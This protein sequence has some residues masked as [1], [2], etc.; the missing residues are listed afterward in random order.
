MKSNLWF[1][2]DCDKGAVGPEWKRLNEQGDV[3]WRR[4]ESPPKCLGCGLRMT[5]LI[6]N[7]MMVDP[8]PSNVAVL[9][10]TEV[11]YFTSSAQTVIS[12]IET[13]E[14]EV[15]VAE[16]RVNE[17]LEIPTPLEHEQD[18]RSIRE[19]LADLEDEQSVC[20]RIHHNECS[21]DSAPPAEYCSFCGWSYCAKHWNEAIVPEGY[22]KSMCGSCYEDEETRRNYEKHLHGKMDKIAANILHQ[23]YGPQKRRIEELED[24]LFI[25]KANLSSMQEHCICDGGEEPEPA[26]PVFP[27]E[28]VLKTCGHSLY[29]PCECFLEEPEDDF[30]AF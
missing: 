20:Q 16:R 24:E 1:C 9:S 17:E 25:V 6:D 7:P 18:E 26:S 10:D 11:F 28:V 29:S 14:H 2:K 12:R 27:V 30:I 19:M 3:L 4:G 21:S 5:P 15:S 23:E 8:P 13:L 22:P